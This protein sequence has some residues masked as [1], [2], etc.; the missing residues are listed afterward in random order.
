MVIFKVKMLKSSFHEFEQFLEIG[1]DEAGRGPLF[2]AVY[3]SAVILPQDDS[4]DH[5]QMKDSKKFYSKKK[6]KSAAEYIKENALA[7]AVT[8][9]TEEEIDSM[10]I[11]QAT[12]ECMKESAS[13]VMEKYEEKYG[14]TH[15]SF[16][17]LVD[18]T[19]F[20]PILKY[21]SVNESMMQVKHLCVEG[22]DNMYTAIAAASILAK[23]ERDNYIERLCEE[24]PD[25]HE[26]YGIQSNK[27]YGAKRHID[28]I[29]EHGITKWHRKTY[30]ICKSFA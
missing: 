26:K 14:K 22:G 28:G 3:T 1:I 29:R 19:H 15:K 10:N 9:K 2:G 11:L 5:S 17:C 27:G 25:L 20:K 7:W 16:Y 21:D 6:L 8:F 30:G 12:L 24:H 23:T 18:G 4:F 13:Q